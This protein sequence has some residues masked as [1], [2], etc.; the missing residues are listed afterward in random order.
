M[1]S[2]Q[3]YLLFS[4]F[5]KSVLYECIKTSG[6]LDT[7]NVIIKGWPAT[8]FCTTDHRYLEE[9]STRSMVTTPELSHEKIAQVLAYKGEQYA[10]PWETRKGE[11]LFKQ[12][13]QQLKTGIEVCIPYGK[14][15]GHWYNQE[16][17]NEPRVMRDYDK[18]MG[19]IEMSAFLYKKDRV[20]F[21]VSF[22]GS[23][24]AVLGNVYL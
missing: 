17:R 21:Q 23:A 18:L 10:K 9:L 11:P 20:S 24:Q 19:P 13:L 4:N 8:I 2:K 6:Q 1:K 14:Q 12:V 5:Y 7:K 16:N 22:N 3:K 15:V